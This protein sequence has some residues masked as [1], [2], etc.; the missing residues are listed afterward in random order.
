MQIS[1]NCF[2]ETKNQCMVFGK[3]RLFKDVFMFGHRHWSSCVVQSPVWHMLDHG[4]HPVLIRSCA[5]RQTA[6]WQLER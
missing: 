3:L 4:S 2:L 5:T 6:A 1:S